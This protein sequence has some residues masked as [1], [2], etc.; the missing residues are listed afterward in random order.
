MGRPHRPRVLSPRATRRLLNFYPPFLFQA[1]RVVHLSDDLRTCRVRV[2]PSWRTRN[3]GG[4]IFGGTIYAAA[5][6]IYAILMWQIAARRGLAVQAWLRG[7]KVRYLKP[8]ATETT[9]EFRIDDEVVEEA[10]DALERHGRWKRWFVTDAVDRAGAV[11]A[12]LET[13]VY[14]RRAGGERRETSGF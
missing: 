4:T 3:L 7:A 1:I 11:C 8:A 5:D 13:E 9:Y 14:L 2:R 12:V 10:V 6:P